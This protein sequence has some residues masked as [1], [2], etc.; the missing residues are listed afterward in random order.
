MYCNYFQT[1]YGKLRY[2]IT[3]RNWNHLGWTEE[4]NMD[5]GPVY[6]IEIPGVVVKS[7]DGLGAAHLIAA[8]NSIESAVE[9]LPAFTLALPPDWELCDEDRSER[10][11]LLCVPLAAPDECCKDAREVC[12]V[13][14][15]RRGE[16]DALEARAEDAQV[17]D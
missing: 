17:Q 8:G 16:C 1:L 2:C 12:F 13:F 10:D 7:A 11:E 9:Q 4:Q 6:E 5:L 15:P 14:S 3:L